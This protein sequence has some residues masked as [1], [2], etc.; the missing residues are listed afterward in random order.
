MSANS[1]RDLTILE[2]LTQRIRDVSTG[3]EKEVQGSYQF[4]SW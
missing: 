3:K 2:A 1:K 4:E